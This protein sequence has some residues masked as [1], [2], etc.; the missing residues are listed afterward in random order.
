MGAREKRGASVKGI[1]T[2]KDVLALLGAL[3]IGYIMLA[4]LEALH[5]L[6]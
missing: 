1:K 3:F 5:V 6:H 2:A 4:M